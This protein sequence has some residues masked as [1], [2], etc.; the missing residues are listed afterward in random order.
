MIFG[1][2]IFTATAP[3]IPPSAYPIGKANVSAAA[4]TMVE[5]LVKFCGLDEDEVNELL[6]WGVRGRKGH[7]LEGRERGGEE[8]KKNDERES[9][10]MA[11]GG[12]DLEVNEND[13]KNDLLN[14]K[15]DGYNLYFSG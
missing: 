12:D 3:K 6:K 4:L 15:K 13:I 2:A 8:E 1:A 14:Y 10:E 5:L 11:H 7:E 9:G